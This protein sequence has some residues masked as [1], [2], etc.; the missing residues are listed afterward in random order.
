MGLALALSLLMLFVF[1]AVLYLK[2][3]V[4]KSLLRNA[5]LVFC[6]L[7]IPLSLEVFYLISS[8]VNVHMLMRHAWCLLF[9]AVIIFYE[10]AAPLCGVSKARL[11][12]WVS[13]GAVFLAVWNYIL[14]SNIA[15]FNMNFRYEKTYALCIKIMDRLEQSEDYDK[16]RPIAFVG[17]YSK[18]YKS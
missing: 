18:T 4:Y 8:G 2:H 9:A 14:L 17:N 12:E 7:C 5:L 13:F 15:Y 10:K 16:D 6:A 3:N 1:T 11:L